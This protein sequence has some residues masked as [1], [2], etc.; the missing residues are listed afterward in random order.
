MIN[1]LS[2]L[3]VPVK[4]MH[5]D[6]FSHIKHYVGSGS[7]LEELEL[8]LLGLYYGIQDTYKKMKDAKDKLR[9]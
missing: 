9:N 7:T 6:P 5:K 3:K 2:D 1:E 8:H 4:I